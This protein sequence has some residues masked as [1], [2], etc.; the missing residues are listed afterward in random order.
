[1]TTAIAI[2]AAGVFLTILGAAAALVIARGAAI[3]DT[4]PHRPRPDQDTQP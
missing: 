1:M 4:R 3:A 2:I